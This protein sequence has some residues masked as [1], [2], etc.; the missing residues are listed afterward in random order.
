MAADVRSI[1]ALRDWYAQLT[2]YGEMLAES[3]SGVELEIRRGMEWLHEQLGR[4]Q[5]AVRDC[6]DEVVQ[7]KAELSARKFPGFDGREPDTTVQERNLRRARARLEYAEDQVTRTRSWI[8]RLPKMVD[9]VYRGPSHRLGG[10]LETD[11]PKALAVLGRQIESL[12]SYSGLRPD[13]A[14]TPSTTSPLPPPAPV[15]NPASPGRQSGEGGTP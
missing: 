15:A 14:P 9:E 3:L 7:A 1:D 10:F 13:Y 4:W 11:L 6:E 2:G 12:E 5:N 8:G